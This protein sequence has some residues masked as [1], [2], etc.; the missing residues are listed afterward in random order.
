MNAAIPS[1]SEIVSRGQRLYDENV[2]AQLEPAH[3]GEVAVINIDT[4][5]FEVDPQHR[6]AVKKAQAR[7]PGGLFFAVRVGYPS[8]G[9]IGARFRNKAE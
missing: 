7:W 4:G 3:R 5:E 1:A 2:R 6:C 9:H 8:M